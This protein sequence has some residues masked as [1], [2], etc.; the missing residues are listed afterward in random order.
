MSY[1]PGG[2]SDKLPNEFER[3]WMVGVALRL[4]DGV[5]TYL[6]WETL[7]SQGEGIEGSAG[8]PTGGILDFQCK[9]DSGGKGKWSL[10]D[11]QGNGVLLAVKKSL[12][13]SVDRRFT[14][15]SRDPAPDLR[16]LRDRAAHCN[17]DP[18]LFRRESLKPERLNKA[19][20]RF[21]RLFDLFQDK[22]E[23]VQ[24]AFTIL[25][26][27]EFEYGWAPPEGLAQLEHY[28]A[29]LAEGSGEAIVSRLG[30][31]LIKRL[32]NRIHLDELRSFLR[33][34]GHAPRDLRCDPG[35]ADGIERLNRNFDH[36]ASACLIGG[37]LLQRAES[38]R[39]FDELQTA[40]PKA[41][42]FVHGGAGSGKSTVALELARKLIAASVPTL[43]ISLADYRPE[44]GVEDYCRKKLELRGTPGACLSALASGR[45]A[46][47]IIDQ[48]DALR[49]TG[50]HSSE[51]WRI[52][53]EILDE[54]VN[55]PNIS[56]VVVCRS[57]DLHDNQSIQ[58]W[59]RNLKERERQGSLKS[60]RVEIT[61]LTDDHVRNTVRTRGVDFDSFPERH[62]ELLRHALALQIW[63][64]VTSNGAPLPQLSTRTALIREF[65][66]D[67]AERLKL[68][69]S[70]S[71]ANTENVLAE[72]ACKLDAMGRLDVSVDQLEAPRSVIA[73][74]MRLGV[75]MQAP[76]NR[77]RFVHQSLL[78]FQIA[79]TVFRRVI[80][81]EQSVIGWICGHDQS[82][83]RRDQ[84]RQLLT[85]LRDEDTCCYLDTLGKLI[86]E[87]G[88]RFHLRHLALGILRDVASPSKEEIAF[89]RELLRDDQWR[90]HV[91][92]EVLLGQGSWFNTLAGCGQLGEWL[93]S[94]D[95]TL[96]GFVAL[97]CRN[98]A[99]T[100]G[101]AIEHLLAASWDGG[102]DG[103]NIVAA[104]LFHRSEGDTDR[105]F[106][107]RLEL[108]R[109]GSVLG[110]FYEAK[111]IAA[112]HPE[113]AI[114]LLAAICER[115]LDELQQ[116]SEKKTTGYDWSHVR[117]HESK[118]IIAACRRHG[119]LAWAQFLPILHRGTRF[120]RKSRR[121]LSYHVR[122]ELQA[123]HRVLRR[124][125]A[126]STRAIVGQGETSVR[127]LLN[128]LSK[129][130]SLV[131][132]RLGVD[133]LLHTS[134]P[135]WANVAITWLCS[136]SSLFE[137][138]S[139]RQYVR[140]G[141]A[142]RLLTRHANQCS[143]SV[144]DV[145]EAAILR[146]HPHSEKQ[147]VEWQLHQIKS[148][149]LLGVN[150]YGR[151][152]NVLLSALPPDR[153][154][155]RARNAAATWRSKFG[156][157]ANDLRRRPRSTGGMVRSPIPGDRLDRV[158][159][160]QWLAIATNERYSERHVGWRQINKEEV[161]E[162]SHEQ[163]SRD[164]ETAA[165]A[166]PPRFAALALRLPLTVHSDYFDSLFRAFAERVAPDTR[167]AAV[168]NWRQADVAEVEA[169]IDR[170]QP[171]FN[172][173]LARSICWMVHRRPSD[174]WSRR[175]IDLLA[176]WATQHPDPADGEFCTGG[177][178]TPDV[179]S[180]A[181]NCVRGS[182]C[183]ALTQVFFDRTDLRFIR[184]KRTWCGGAS[185]F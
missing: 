65:F 39:L 139:R 45:P 150:N 152:Q 21:C 169:I 97:L 8:L 64:V 179:N 36:A 162:S 9:Q 177:D 171:D 11:L 167:Y 18:A 69:E 76:G 153:L 142:A 182:A 184:L 38:Q 185:R 133:V 117:Q 106:D 157:A 149:Y 2:R 126:A 78:D 132:K 110:D 136:N 176:T 20:S 92:R 125:L 72:I 16:D 30:D 154:S 31:F 138:G 81:N 47:L 134:G 114:R 165:K 164:F 77:V 113:R 12:L 148:G 5:Y 103:R 70:A 6:E 17:N 128:E 32:G 44:S 40:S 53:R 49:W 79:R 124:L 170:L 173:P 59:E 93:D 91:V 19:F 175:T 57:F 123:F 158:S 116:D 98:S 101:P 95:P 141:P 183:D 54:A 174:P 22:D 87:P 94:K 135:H 15:V 61:G 34:G 43:S 99:T 10:A 144:Y 29:R 56:I 104:A 140:Q 121:S 120:F 67:R 7:D 131:L 151:A 27:I 156:D 73:G 146:Y 159:N 127:A 130:P 13:K 33:E 66:Q 109:A 83:F 105:M 62:R 63:C 161:A 35:V 147:S 115:S 50:V 172:S 3:H 60:F 46:V 155:E 88:V 119:S 58:A 168:N 68:E 90:S 41:V 52:C 112:K 84:L 55:A 181:I 107:W 108:I 42:V 100:C 137:L 74:L 129:Q 160:R 96:I 163:F 145:L 28:A 178:K 89:V 82:L 75:L 51:A 80:S 166:N 23:D 4:L 85:L 71:P 26:R 24:T 14:F 122:R 102:E 118:E 111:D 86:R 180:S 25:G 143:K 48:L 1:E 37:E